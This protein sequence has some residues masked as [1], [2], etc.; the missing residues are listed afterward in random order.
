MITMM[1]MMMMMM[2]MIMICR[3]VSTW[4]K[5]Q[6]QARAM[7]PGGDTECLTEKQQKAGLAVLKQRFDEDRGCAA[8]RMGSSQGPRD[9]LVLRRAQERIRRGGLWTGLSH[10]SKR[11]RDDPATEAGVARRWWRR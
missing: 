1:M 5:S 3:G 9:A 8:G 10:G 6:D 2:M 7:L 11:H 4:V